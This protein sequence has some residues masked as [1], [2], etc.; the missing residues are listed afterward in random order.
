MKKLILIIVVLLIG[1]YSTVEP[2][3][4]AACMKLCDGE[5]KKVGDGG[6]FIYCTC[7]DGSK[8]RKSKGN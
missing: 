1:C 2:G 3:E 7:T 4:W 5:I 8:L 6:R